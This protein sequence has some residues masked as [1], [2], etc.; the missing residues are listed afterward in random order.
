MKNRPH[1][2]FI[3]YHINTY[4]K[5]CDVFFYSLVIDV[6]TNVFSAFMSSPY[7]IK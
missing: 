7:R 2:T 1:L 6:A 5:T 4:V 3:Q